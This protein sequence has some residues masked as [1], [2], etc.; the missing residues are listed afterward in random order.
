MTIIIIKNLYHKL[1]IVNG[2]INYIKNISV[3]KS[4]WIQQDHSMHPPTNVYVDLKEFIK[5]HDTLHDITLEGLPKNVTPIVL[6]SKTFQYH[7]QIP[8]SN[9]SKTF[10]INRYQLFVS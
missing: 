3:N 2:T 8:Q 9:T 7:H 5:K 10:Y 1:R 4:Q 6:I